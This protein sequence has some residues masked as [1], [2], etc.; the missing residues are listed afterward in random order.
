MHGETHRPDGTNP[1]PG[2]ARAPEPRDVLVDHGLASL[3]F[4]VS[5][6][7]MISPL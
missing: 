4:L 6:R 7:M 2:L 1:E 5:L 3:F